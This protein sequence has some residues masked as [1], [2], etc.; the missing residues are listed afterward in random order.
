MFKTSRTMPMYRAR[1]IKPMKSNLLPIFVMDKVIKGFDVVN[2]E[3]TDCDAVLCRM[4]G[5]VVSFM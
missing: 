2:R 5:R 4:A 1:N 3:N